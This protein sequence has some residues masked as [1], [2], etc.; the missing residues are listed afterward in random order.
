ML[1]SNT[2]PRVGRVQ[3]LLPQPPDGDTQG[4]FAAGGTQ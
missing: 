2:L 1:R 4:A 3:R